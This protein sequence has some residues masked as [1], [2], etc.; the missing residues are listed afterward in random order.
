MVDFATGLAL[1]SL[2]SGLGLAAL[3]RVAWGH[4][5][6]PGAAGAVL[7]LG[8]GT[9]W[10][11]TY[12]VRLLVGD[13]TVSLYAGG[14]EMLC[15]HA[16][17]VGWFLL[18]VEFERGRR[19]SR[20]LRAALFV[21]PA[22]TLLALLTNDVYHLVYTPATGMNAGGHLDPSYGPWYWLGPVA[23]NYF[24]V[25]GGGALLVNRFLNARGF[26][27]RQLAT[28]LVAGLFEAGL[29]GLGFL[30]RLQT[31][32][33]SYL[34]LTPV[35]FLPAGALI[36][37]AFRNYRMF[38]FVPIGRE[39][40][41]AEMTDAMVTLD[42][43][44]TVVDANQAA[45]ALFDPDQN[46]VG[47]DA[48]ALFGDYP[49]VADRLADADSLDEELS[50]S[51]DG[52]RRYFDLSVS[53]V[54]DDGS[55]RGR[56]VVLRD[57]TDL[58]RRE[59]E[60]DLA[61]QV[62]SRVLRHN[63]RN[64]LSV[65]E[66]YAEFIADGDDER[67]AMADRIVAKTDDLMETSAKARAVE[68]VIGRDADRAT[69]DLADVVAGTVDSL[70]ETYPSVTVDCDVDPVTVRADRALDVAVWNVLENAAEHGAQPSGEAARETAAE[71]GRPGASAVVEDGGAEAAAGGAAAD[72]GGGADENGGA[73]ERDGAAAEGDGAA[74]GG[75]DVAVSTTVAD[76]VIE[77][78]VRDRG[79]GIPESELRVLDRGEETPLEHGSG[80]G[81]WL[82]DWVV[83]KSGGDLTVDVDDGTTVTMT[84]DRA[85][86]AAS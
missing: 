18:A 82:A 39:R 5:G 71:R 84:F 51:V 1:V 69:V 49:A 17:S 22:V 38:E 40:A 32:T 25:T 15:G 16:A 55:G 43:D 45:V 7:L 70:R 79:P 72:D 75:P 78:R 33:Y 37:F 29:N 10:S 6:K 11:L 46:P 83:E 66:G 27:R 64:D 63:I 48:D 56:L 67:A 9:V 41:M 60:L 34:D 73:V 14:L 19:V 68:R 28:L 3:T 52:E 65:V 57:V 59:A 8:G 2:A 47:R 44:G 77:L 35:G 58:K 85:D 54:G 62:L 4:R 30:V 36:A 12:G 42:A 21:V 76:D 50:L 80:L 61:Q 81:L 20:R 74:A 13:L 31:T 26:Q 86:P 23:Y 24:V 53:P